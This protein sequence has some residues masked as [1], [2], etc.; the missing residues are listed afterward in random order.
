MNRKHFFLVVHFI[1][2]C[3]IFFRI[4]DYEEFSPESEKLPFHNRELEEKSHE[5]IKIVFQFNDNTRTLQSRHTISEK[6]LRHV[7]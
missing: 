2:Y 6:K 1:S 3:Y 5:A 7:A 4:N